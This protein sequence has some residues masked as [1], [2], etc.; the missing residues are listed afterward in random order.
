MVTKDIVVLSEPTNTAEE[1]AAVAALRS[2]TL[3]RAIGHCG[4]RRGVIFAGAQA[5]EVG[6]RSVAPEN[7]HT[8]LTFERMIRY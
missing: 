5:A 1:M 4:V 6:C 8:S 2:D 3:N 7:L